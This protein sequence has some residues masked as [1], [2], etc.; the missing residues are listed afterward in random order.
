MMI[1]VPDSKCMALNV[2]ARTHQFR[3]RRSFSATHDDPLY[4]PRKEASSTACLHVPTALQQHWSSDSI[5]YP[6]HPAREMADCQRSASKSES[7][8]PESSCSRLLSA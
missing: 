4:N 1:E 7:H 3:R 8:Q 2:S 5:R 6:S